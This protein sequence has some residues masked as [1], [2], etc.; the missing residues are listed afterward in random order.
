SI[1]RAPSV[2]LHILAVLGCMLAAVGSL[3]WASRLAFIGELELLRSLLT[4]RLFLLAAA[5][6]CFATAYLRRATEKSSSGFRYAIP[7][8]CAIQALHLFL[9]GL[10]QLT[11]GYIYFTATSPEAAVVAVLI[12][13]FMVI[14][15]FVDLTDAAQRN[16]AAKSLFLS[17]M[18]HELRTPLAG[19]IGLT[20]ILSTSKTQEEQKELASSINQCATSVLALVDDILDVARIEAGRTQ[21][22]P[23]PFSPLA[24]IQEIVSMFQATAAE[25]GVLLDAVL[26]T[27]LPSCISSD[28][29]LF[30]RILL[31][32]VANALKFTDAGSVTIRTSYQMGALQCS[33]ED[34][35]CGIPEQDLPQLMQQFFQ[36]SNAVSASSKGTGLG[37]H[38]SDHM[39]KLLGGSG[40]KVQSQLYRGSTFSFTIPAPEAQLLPAADTPIRSSSPSLRV[41]VAEDNKV[42]QLVLIRLLEKLGHST[43]LA[44]DGRQAVNHW[45]QQNPDLILMDYRMPV[46]DGPAAAREIR[47]LEDGKR[48][49]PILALTANA[50]TEHRDICLD[51]GMDDYLSKPLTIQQLAKA[52]ER[53]IAQKD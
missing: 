45:Q 52:I 32:L 29:A 31:N 28:P 2:H 37:L 12:G 42:N 26:D 51:A 47:S 13:L 34:T 17:T 19:M 48:H 49:V 41:L 43:I 8:P 5:N 50:L 24:T 6:L 21:A 38:L 27:P 20:S 11:G 30:R 14:A 39:V 46:L 1:R 4:S 53:S 35:G 10:N 15:L 18:T 25:K 23:T 9:L 22:T 33:V 16:N 44:T 3:L 36:A 7:V 40:I